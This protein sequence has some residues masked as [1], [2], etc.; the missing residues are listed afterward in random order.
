MRVD[1]VTLR[2]V[3]HTASSR[4]SLISVASFR[5]KH[6]DHRESAS[7]ILTRRGR[8]INPLLSLPIK[9][10]CFIPCASFNSYSTVRAICHNYYSRLPPRS[11]SRKAAS[12]PNHTKNPCAMA[13]AS[14]IRLSSNTPGVFH[15]PNIAEVSAAKASE[16]LQENH[17]NHHIFFNQ[18]GFHS[19]FRPLRR[20][21]CPGLLKFQVFE[22][23]YLRAIR[24]LLGMRAL[25]SRA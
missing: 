11:Y 9:T 12:S 24:V 21:S 6:G 18:S 1:S 8:D 16:V 4:L 14:R 10:D 7:M 20:I 3:I 13:T 15:V 5:S 25:R 17:D 23:L 2:Q 19:R 22:S